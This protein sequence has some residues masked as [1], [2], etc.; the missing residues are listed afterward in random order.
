MDSS[1]DWAEAAGTSGY[2]LLHTTSHHF[3]ACDETLGFTA[4]RVSYI[5]GINDIFAVLQNYLLLPIPLK[6]VLLSISL[7]SFYICELSDFI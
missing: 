1:P 2:T 5:S 4:S 6:L 3:E 7:Y